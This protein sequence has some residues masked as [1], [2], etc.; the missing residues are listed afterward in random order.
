MAWSKRRR[1]LV[2]PETKGGG[3]GAGA[4]LELAGV[5]MKGGGAGALLQLAN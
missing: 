1:I 4:S 5:E 2:G 3:V